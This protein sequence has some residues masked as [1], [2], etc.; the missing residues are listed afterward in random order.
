[1]VTFLFIT[2]P[3]ALGQ[4]TPVVTDDELR[5]LVVEYPDSVL[6]I[7]DRLEKDKV[8]EWPSY[9]IN[10]MRA[11]A[12]NEKR[13]YAFVNKYAQLTLDDDSI[14]RHPNIKLNALTSIANAHSFFGDLQ[15][16]INTASRA[17]D[18]ARTHNN[19]VAE[20][21]A[22]A[23]MANA[24]FTLGN[25]KTGYELLEQVICKG[26]DSDDVRV[27]AN[28][29]S[30]YGTKIIQ[31]YT[32]DRYDEGLKEGE[33]R[34]ALIA[35]MKKKGGTPEGYIDQQKA[36]TY[37]RI[38][39]CAQLAG[40]T[41]SALDAYRKFLATEYG[42]SDIGKCYITDYLLTSGN[43]TTV[44]AY[45]TPLHSE[46]VRSDTINI[47]YQSMLTA[48]ARANYGLG[49]YK[50]GYD[51]LQRANVIQDSLI[52]RENVSRAQELATVFQLNEKDLE[53]QKSNDES[54]MRLIL[55]WTSV[56]ILV[57][58]V[59]ILISLL[60]QY[61]I[62]RKHNRLAAK[63]IDE[64]VNIHDMEHDTALTESS[65]DDLTLFRDLESKLI[66]NKLFKEQNLNRDKPTETIGLPRT[67]ITQLIRLYTGLTPGDYIN[68]LRV[69][70]SVK[71]IKEHPEWTIDGI[72]EECGY[73]RRATYYSNFNKFYGITPAQYRK[74]LLKNHTVEENPMTERT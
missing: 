38:A 29:S 33:K 6:H 2:T 53:L 50:A 48:E 68:R 55:F 19:L 74:E 1:M 17:I 56:A 57:F 59:I 63:R 24:N 65:D 9:K 71:L 49:N 14:D 58:V 28:V 21:H 8:A 44:L 15:G 73:C 61:R 37:A 64:L 4:H 47:D 31:L 36:Y 42:Q 11:I 12:Y 52:M 25:R 70:Y 16:A 72:A 39:S 27:L 22:L 69:E 30:A 46:Y 3:Q 13:M 5:L 26:S 67:K 41:A 40:N 62:V 23:T 35:E 18:I 60:R 20:M 43:Y 34:L 10:M 51:L 66:N 7:L 54:R 32:D 45:L